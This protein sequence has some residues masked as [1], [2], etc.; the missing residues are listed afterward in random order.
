MSMS[1]VVNCPTCGA[2]CRV[3]SSDEG[4]GSYQPV[5][6]APVAE[7][8][9]LDDD[10]LIVAAMSAPELGPV[11]AVDAGALH[12]IVA[13][14]RDHILRALA[15]QAGDAETLYDVWLDAYRKARD[16]KDDIV[17][18][19]VVKESEAA[20]IAAV[21]VR[22]RAEAAT[23]VAGLREAI[24]GLLPA[25]IGRNHTR[26]L[27]DCVQCG[28]FTARTSLNPCVVCRVSQARRAL[29]DPPAPAV[30]RL[31]SEARLGRAEWQ[32]ERI[33]SEV[34]R[35]RSL[36]AMHKGDEELDS[37]KRERVAALEALRAL[38]GGD[39]A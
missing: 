35:A 7:V 11:F 21:A 3:M 4:T 23:E 20:G 34:R 14:V 24:C 2:T 30:A 12:T 38:E 33:R 19:V 5:E 17:A 10:A 39:K 1:D 16:G 28:Q 13:A 22:V 27:T 32:V 25:T 8:A 18:R 36:A 31:E 29:D 26:D 15:Q 9:G 37:A 6:A